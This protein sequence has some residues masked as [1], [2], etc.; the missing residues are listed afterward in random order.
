[1]TNIWKIYL[2]NGQ[3]MYPFNLFF[4]SFSFQKIYYELVLKLS[5]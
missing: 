5:D 2:L 4:V 1:M 3:L